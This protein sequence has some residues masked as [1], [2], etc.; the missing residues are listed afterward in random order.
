MRCV[1]LGENGVKIACI[2]D[3]KKG[4]VLIKG[5]LGTVEQVFKGDDIIFGEDGSTVEIKS[6]SS[7]GYFISRL[8]SLLKGVSEGYF[9]ELEISGRGYRFINLTDKLLVK[10]GSMH[11]IGIKQSS[12]IKIVGT[13]S[14]VLIFGLDIEEVN[15]VANIIR[16]FRVPDAYKGKGIR[17][18]GEQLVLKVGKKS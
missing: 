1:W 10:L 9:V 15:R 18:V 3:K 13:K 5:V 17:Y 7:L 6:K 4:S 16:G 11:Y 2:L 8:N 12:G 14:K